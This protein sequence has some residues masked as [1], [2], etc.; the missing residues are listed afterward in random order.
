M[1]ILESIG[2]F[3]G[4]IFKYIGIMVIKFVDEIAVGTIVILGLVA[5]IVVI[6]RIA[7]K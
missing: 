2:Q 3:F 6:R 5:L 4:F 1:K 7:K